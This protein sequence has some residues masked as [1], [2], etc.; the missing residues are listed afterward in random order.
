MSQCTDTPYSPLLHHHSNRSWADSLQ[1]VVEEILHLIELK[2]GYKAVYSIDI[3]PALYS[4]VLGLKTLPSSNTRFTLFFYC[5]YKSSRPEKI[6]S[7]SN[8]AS[9]E[10]CPSLLQNTSHR[11]SH[12]W[13]C[14]GKHTSVFSRVRVCWS[15]DWLV[16][17]TME[18]VRHQQQPFHKLGNWTAE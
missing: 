10:G 8:R 12:D 5:S 1:S 18:V 4:W 7:I 13:E 6:F 11:S 15:V 16:P 3:F 2:L 14:S 9:M 17:D